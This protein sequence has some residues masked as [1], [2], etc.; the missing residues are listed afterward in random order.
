[1]KKIL[2]KYIDS[3][4]LT[5]L[6][7]TAFSQLIP[8]LASLILTRIYQPSQFGLYAAYFAVVFPLSIISSLRYEMTIIL[9]R[10]IQH[11]SMLFLSSTI[12]CSIFCCILWVILAGALTFYQPSDVLYINY[13][14]VQLIPV[15]VFFT[16]FFQ[17]MSIWSNRL[18]TYGILAQARIY[19]TIISAIFSIGLGYLKAD[20]MSLILG[21]ITGL[22]FGNTFILLRHRKTF[23]FENSS[24]NYLYRKSLVLLKENIKTP[25]YL[26]PAHL[27]N[28]IYSQIPIYLFSFFYGPTVV[29]YFSLAQRSVRLP[30]AVISNSF[31]EV[32]RQ[33]ASQLFTS[34]KSIVKVYKRTLKKLIIIAAAP[35]LV[36]G[37]MGPSL[38]SFFFGTTW[39]ESG[40]YVQVLVIMYFMQFIST[41]FN[42]IFLIYQRQDIELRINVISVVLNTMILVVGGF[43]HIDI[44]LIIGLYSVLNA[45]IYLVFL[46]NSYKVTYK[47]YGK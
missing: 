24:L 10:R 31:G 7:G 43:L 23:C 20:V 46:K 26:L 13:S 40:A 35:F 8:I 6:S 1:M 3:S 33:R 2:E 18:E 11:A 12:L 29:G 28:A 4:V 30:T 22:F 17:I 45:L 34:K 41:P 19:Q 21:N 44:F 47:L 14:W 32:F 15:G 25:K 42:S 38:F 5:L 39:N 16:T 36:L 27:I 9:P 37:L